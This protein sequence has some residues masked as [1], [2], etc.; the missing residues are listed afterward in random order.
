[1]YL[2]KEKITPL[3]S[4]SVGYMFNKH[5]KNT[6][7]LSKD[8]F[9]PTNLTLQL[10]GCQMVPLLGRAKSEVEVLSMKTITR[11]INT[12]TIRWTTY[13]ILNERVM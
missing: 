5:I 4:N 6:K 2:H 3:S 12:K 10:K 8:C 11:G 1:M 9:E 7:T 13:I